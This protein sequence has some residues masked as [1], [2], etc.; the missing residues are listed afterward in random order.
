MKALIILSAIATLNVS[1]I[2][3]QK[4]ARWEFGAQ[5]D[6]G[7]DWYHRNYY[8]LESIPNGYIQN[9]PSY[10]STGAGIF[11]ERVLNQKFSLLGQLNYLQ[12]KMPAD[13]FGERSSTGSRWVTKEIHHRGA[14]DFGLRWY[15]NP[16]SQ[17]RFFVDGKLG[18]NMLVAA[19]QHVEG[20]GKVVTRDAF[21]YRR[22]NPVGSASAGV[23]WRRLAISAEYRRDLAAVK[24]ERSA[25][26]IKSQTLVGKAALTLFKAP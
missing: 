7:K 16:K 23:K 22:V 18:A 21:G 24:R 2:H 25:T 11:A 17:I 12:K 13:M 4:T 9:F 3:A 26:G 5:V 14:V 15:V 6:L 10:H 8:G 20:F 19:V 1:N